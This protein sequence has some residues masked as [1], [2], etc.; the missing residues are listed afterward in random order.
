MERVL[1]EGPQ[2]QAARDAGCVSGEGQPNTVCG[3][4]QGGHQREPHRGDGLPGGDA[5]ELQ[6]GVA[7]WSQQQPRGRPQQQHRADNGDS[8]RGRRARTTSFP[9][10]EG[11]LRVGPRRPCAHLQDIA[12]EEAGV[13]TRHDGLVHPSVVAGAQV[14]HLQ[15]PVRTRWGG[16][17]D[18]ACGPCLT[19][20]SAPRLLAVMRVRQRGCRMGG[21]VYRAQKD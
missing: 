21:K 16:G 14:A 9:G 3:P 8:R 7:P 4:L 10:A 6:P 5:Q 19:A 12:V 11:G 1:E 15:Q 20:T 17:T 18:Q 2:Q 13:G